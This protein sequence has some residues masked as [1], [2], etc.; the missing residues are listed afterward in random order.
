MVKIAGK[1]ITQEELDK[2]ITDKTAAD[3]LAKGLENKITE[4]ESKTEGLDELEALKKENQAN[5]DKIYANTLSSRLGSI[6][7]YLD[8]KGKSEDLIKRIG[9]MSD[10]DFDF[11]VEGKTDD[12]VKTDEEIESAKTDLDNE[13]TELEKNKDK[14]IKEYLK[15]IED[16]NKTKNDQNL[17]PNGEIDA[18]DGDAGTES[19]FPTNDELKTIYRLHNNPI[20]DKNERMIENAKTYMDEYSEKPAV[21]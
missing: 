16:E 19:G 14:I 17:V 5:K 8:K 2:F 11:F 4:L 10:D 21:L 18:D 9:D 12:V 6:T 15:G 3:A 7:K 1:E 20:F 13:K